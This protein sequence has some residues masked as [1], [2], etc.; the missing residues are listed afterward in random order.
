MIPFNETIKSYLLS[1]AKLSRG[2]KL[3]KPFYSGIG[4]ILLFHR[5]CKKNSSRRI[6]RCSGLEVTPEYLD[7]TIKFFLDRHYNIVSLDQL[8]DIFEKRKI[9]NKIV[10]FTLDDGYLDNLTF[11]Y[12][13][14]KKYNIPFAIYIT[15][16]FADKCAAPWWYLLED[17]V[18]KTNSIVFEI[19]KKKLEFRCVTLD[20]KEKVFLEIGFI[21]K[22]SNEY[23]YWDKIH[24]I[25][26]LNK[27]EIHKKT[28][29][30]MLNWQ[31]IRDLTSDPLVTLGSHSV[32]HYCLA[33]LSESGVRYEILESK[34]KLESQ[35]NLPVKHF[36]YPFGGRGEVGRREFKITKECGFQ[37]AVTGRSANIFFGH[38]LYREALPR[39]TMGENLDHQRLDF[40]INGLLHCRN[41]SFKRVVTE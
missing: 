8:S 22:N 1:I 30:I 11:A 23:N 38:R 37:T 21:I 26:N 6:S 5:V 2:Y 4:H 39:I 9:N 13:V 40:L 20:E 7:A 29:E 16:G 19:E 14:F 36:S 34:N 24:Q 41:N 18:L 10:V 3:I 33:S 31:Q 15:T 25:F 12:P 17:L 32:N 28:E 35:I 27:H